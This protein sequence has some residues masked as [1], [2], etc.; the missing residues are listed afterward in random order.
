MGILNEGINEVIATTKG[1]AA[2][3]GVIVRNG[4][5]RMVCFTGTH[6]EKNIARDRWVVANIVHDPILFVRTAFSDLPDSAFFEENVAGTPMDRLVEAEAWIAFSGIIE[7]RGAQAMTVRLV[8]AT[9]KVI[10][11]RPHPV[12]RGFF[13]IIEATVHA[14]RYR[15]SGDPELKKLIDHYR[16]IIRKCGGP[17]EHEALDLLD[18]YLS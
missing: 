16:T 4:I 9:E 13:A 14:T 15:L 11:C 7:R 3:M 6:T 10:A 5:Y 17:R 12:N 1:N 18:S 2:P 8:P